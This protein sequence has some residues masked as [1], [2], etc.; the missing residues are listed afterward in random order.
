MFYGPPVADKMPIVL[1]NSTAAAIH[2]I[3]LSS[4]HDG[5]ITHA[6]IINLSQTHSV[7]HILHSFMWIVLIIQCF[8]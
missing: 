1:I 5:P 4:L 3:I 7:F 6:A 2:N 8:C